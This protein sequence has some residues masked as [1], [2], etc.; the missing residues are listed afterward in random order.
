MCK[1]CTKC[2][3][4]YENVENNFHKKLKS[5]RPICKECVKE[6]QQREDVKQRARLQ[7]SKHKD[8]V[9]PK[10]KKYYQDNR[11]SI[12]K[13]LKPYKEKIKEQKEQFISYKKEW[14]KNNLEKIKSYKQ[15]NRQALTDGYVRS[16]I[17]LSKTSYVE[18]PT[19]E[20]IEAYRQLTLFRRSKKELINLT[21]SLKDGNSINL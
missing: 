15:K 7:P 1:T 6:Y 17:H 21:K 5:F 19:P 14:Q 16:L 11:N 8:I 20:Y 9:N 18:N 3:V 12:L 13:K 2:N 4:T 10:A